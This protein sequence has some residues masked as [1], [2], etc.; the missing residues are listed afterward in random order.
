[1]LCVNTHSS[2]QRYKDYWLSQK[3]NFLDFSKIK[4][5]KL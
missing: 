1:M 4:F 5:S 3:S 2:V